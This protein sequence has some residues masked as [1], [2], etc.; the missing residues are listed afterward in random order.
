MSLGLSKESLSKMSIAQLEGKLMEAKEQ[1]KAAST[2]LS[3]ARQNQILKGKTIR[4]NANKR[5]AELIAQIMKI[6]RATQ[7]VN[8]QITQINVGAKMAFQ[9]KINTARKKVDARRRE[10]KATGSYQ[11]S[12]S[13]KELVYHWCDCMGFDEED[14]EKLLEY[15][16]FDELAEMS[17]DEFYDQMQDAKAGYDPSDRVTFEPQEEEESV[18]LEKKQKLRKEIDLTALL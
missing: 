2:N 16:T 12:L 6:N 14:L 18:R 13:N 15:Y 3:E 1:F 9:A 8:A 11:T 5:K 7:K 17:G 10:L 4:G